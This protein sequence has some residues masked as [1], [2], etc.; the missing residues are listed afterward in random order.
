MDRPLS[1][2]S[3]SYVLF[4]NRPVR[5][6]MLAGGP[7]LP[8]LANVGS[9]RTS[10]P[11]V[12]QPAGRHLFE[13]WASA[14]GQRPPEAPSRLQPATLFRYPTLPGLATIWPVYAN[15][16]SCFELSNRTDMPITLESIEN[17]ERWAGTRKPEPL[18]RLRKSEAD[19]A[20]G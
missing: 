18:L 17:P 14:R 11:F 4:R 15:Y 19:L 12:L 16:L 8:A 2:A 20:S 7:Y 9:G 6:N 1:R 13:P 3:V 5:Q 10:D